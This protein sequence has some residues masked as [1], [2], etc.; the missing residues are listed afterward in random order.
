M[1]LIKRLIAGLLYIVVVSILVV[2]SFWGPI[3][4]FTQSPWW[5]LEEVNPDE[6]GSFFVAFIS[7]DSEVEEKQLH[8]IPGIDPQKEGYSGVQYYMPEDRLSYSWPGGQEA[9]VNVKAEA[10][11]SQIIQIFVVGEV[12]WT[13]LSEYR[14]VGNKIYPLRHAHSVQMVWWLLGTIICMFFVS[15]LSTPIKH[16]IKKFMRIEPE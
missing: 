4:M 2:G 10:L 8:V 13:S 5:F 7:E 11:G 12:A 15:K 9:S 1:N 3:V 14:V 6:P 16:G